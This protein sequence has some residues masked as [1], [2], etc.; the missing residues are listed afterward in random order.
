M[1]KEF[2]ED[3][4]GAGPAVAGP[5]IDTLLAAVKRAHGLAEG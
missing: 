3:P 5:N 2:A 4:L 1:G